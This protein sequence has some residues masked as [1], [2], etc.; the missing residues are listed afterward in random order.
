MQTY[1]PDH[2][3][4]HKPH[5]WRAARLC[6]GCCFQF[7]AV[8]PPR[9]AAT[10]SWCGATGGK[11]LVRWR[12]RLPWFA[13]NMCFGALDW[14]STAPCPSFFELLGWR[15]SCLAK[16][17]DATLA[18]A[19]RFGFGLCVQ[20]SLVSCGRWNSPRVSL[21]SVGVE[22][23]RVKLGLH[24][25][26]LNVSRQSEA[27]KAHRLGRNANRPLCKFA[28]SGISVKSPRVRPQQIS[29]GSASVENASSFLSPKC[30]SRRHYQQT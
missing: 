2:S 20:R 9:Q 19:G 12:S 21:L 26:Y 28:G 15:T 25:L 3:T 18:L 4:V 29:K 8:P 1:V 23:K 14:M 17:A 10:W 30:S 22:I 5:N 16:L 27:G 13:A 7:Q 11:R 6:P 24:E